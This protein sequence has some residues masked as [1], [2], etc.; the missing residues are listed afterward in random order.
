VIDT[1]GPSDNTL[2]SPVDDERLQRNQDRNRWPKH[3]QIVTS[4]DAIQA[5]ST[6]PNN[7]KPWQ[8]LVTPTLLMSS[9]LRSMKLGVTRAS[10]D[11]FRVAQWPHADVSAITRHGTIF[12]KDSRQ[13]SS[14]SD[15]NLMTS[16]SMIA[17]VKIAI[18]F[19]M[20]DPAAHSHGKSRY[21]KR[22]CARFCLFR[23]RP[24]E[25]VLGWS[26]LLALAEL[27]GMVP[28]SANRRHRLGESV[29]RFRSHTTTIAPGVRTAR[30]RAIE[31]RASRGPAASRD[32]LSGAASSRFFLRERTK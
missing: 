24:W 4:S 11:A 1:A 21:N 19:Y 17:I 32:F 3:L 29:G 14:T 9:C 18:D 26:A 27:S 7:R 30:K 5:C 8:V 16:R 31:A 20:A 6:Y 25:F 10:P 28:N 15:R 13:G 23:S 2:G 12:A 22:C